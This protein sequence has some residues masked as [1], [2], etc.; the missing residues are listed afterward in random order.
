MAELFERHKIWVAMA[1]SLAFVFMC[2]SMGKDQALRDNRVI[3]TIYS[4]EDG[5]LP[6]D[7]NHTRP[8]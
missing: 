5:A 8:S 4:L 6:D 7:H 3:G 1:C 2:Y